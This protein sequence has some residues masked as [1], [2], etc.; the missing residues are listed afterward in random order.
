MMARKVGQIIRKALGMGTGVKS[1][2]R[3][4]VSGT[5]VEI[6]APV[7]MW[8]H[9]ISAGPVRPGPAQASGDKDPG[10]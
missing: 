9:L 10:S 1:R 8:P 5:L 3:L 6:A 4:A 7:P 2:R